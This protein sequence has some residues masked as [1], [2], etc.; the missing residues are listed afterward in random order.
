M[1]G[2]PAPGLDDWQ[3]G[4]ADVKRR[5]APDQG[6]VERQQ[7][8]LSAAAGS[9][10]ALA[11]YL[12]K[13]LRISEESLRE[14]PTLGGVTADEMHNTPVEWER[15]IA[16]QLREI[17]PRQALSTEWWYVCHTAWLQRGVFPDPP[18]EAFKARVG[19]DLLD[20]TVPNTDSDAA[21]ALDEATRSLLRRL[22]GLPHIRRGYRVA[23]DP[24][25]ARAYWRSRLADRAAEAAPAQAGLEAERCQ[26]M[27]HGA[28]WGTFVERTQRRFSSTLQPRAMAAVC[29]IAAEDSGKVTKDHV[30]TVARRCLNSHP[31][32]A[33]WQA[34]T[35]PP[36]AMPSVPPR[37]RKKRGRNRSRAKRRR[38]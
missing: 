23:T 33:D 35:R 26:D 30:Q 7:E 32:L 29:A 17:A 21:K 14:V 28:G 22:G 20:R 6:L 12:V 34:L 11:A 24:P 4:L 19:R 3:R 2:R 9:A 10:A 5:A 15:R 8:F 1:S 38:R 27:L 16:S 25:I 36:T 31:E 13:H 37:P 18:D